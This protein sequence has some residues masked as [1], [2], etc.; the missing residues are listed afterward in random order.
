M[1]RSLV[2]SE[3]CI[4]DRYVL[5]VFLERRARRRS[6]G[7]KDLVKNPRLWNEMAGGQ[8]QI[9]DVVEASKRW[10]DEQIAKAL[11][12]Y[13][14]KSKTKRGAWP[15]YKAL[16]GL[17]EIVHPP[18]LRLLQDESHRQKL[19][20]PTGN[21]GLPETPFERACDLLGDTP[22]HESLEA[23]RPVSYTHL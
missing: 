16:S 19:V 13:V 20:T 21:D 3:M 1:L 11:E 5:G 10:S 15:L 6:W 17:G 9:D 12:K 4:R 7:F 2:G 8:E 23:V 22:P 14:F 18:V